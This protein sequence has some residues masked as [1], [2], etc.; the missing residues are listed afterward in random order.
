[1]MEVD[2]VERAREAV[3]SGASSSAMIEQEHRKHSEH[4][5]GMICSG[6]QTV[7]LK[8]L[9]AHDLAV[10]ESARPGTQLAITANGFEVAGIGDTDGFKR[11][12]DSGFTYTETLGPM[13]DVYIIGGGHCALA[14]SEL[15]SRMDFY[16]HIFDDRPQLNTIAKNEFADEI[17]IIGGYGSIGEHIQRGDNVFVVVMTLGYV[18]DATVIRQLADRDLK[19]FGVLGSRAKMSALFRELKAEGFSAESLARIRTP[20]GIPINS[21]TPD[22]IAISIAAEIISVKNK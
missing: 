11:S 5:S 16:V 14:L 7:I 4:P 19:Y 3:K 18:T 8:Q 20:I 21:H 9:H 22:E 17:T 12:N 15:M 6:E 10:V 1:V 13:N 2:L